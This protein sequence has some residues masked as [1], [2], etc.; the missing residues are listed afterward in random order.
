MFNESCNGK[1]AHPHSACTYQ[2]PIGAFLQK[3]AGAF[4]QESTQP[5]PPHTHFSGKR[6]ANPTIPAS[7]CLKQH[8]IAGVLS[9]LLKYSKPW[10]PLITWRG[11]TPWKGGRTVLR[12]SQRNETTQS[13]AGENPGHPQRLRPFAEHCCGHP[14][15]W[16]PPL[17]GSQL[18]LCRTIHWTHC[19]T[20]KL[21][22]FL[23]H[24]TSS[25]IF[26]G[27]TLGNMQAL[28]LLSFQFTPYKMMMVMMTDLACLPNPPKVPVVRRLTPELIHMERDA[29]LSWRCKGISQG[30]HKRDST[31]VTRCHAHKCSWQ[32][33]P[34]RLASARIWPK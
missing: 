27:S 29:L 13:V 6:T 23:Q 9:T 15:G 4:S 8:G 30:P 3:N 19:K 28:P 17:G 2:I 33:A 18:P 11:H 31:Q 5:T 32:A 7:V 21:L 22:A 1:R 34:A 26:T 12:P 10:P 20:P 16:P 25:F 14:S 24:S